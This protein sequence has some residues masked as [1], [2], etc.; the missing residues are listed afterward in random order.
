MPFPGQ[1][2][3]HAMLLGQGRFLCL[4]D[5]T[6]V[7]RAL[8]ASGFWKSWLSVQAEQTGFLLELLYLLVKLLLEESVML[9]PVKTPL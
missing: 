8:T 7:V 4:R 9:T 5:L 3:N 1:G 6:Q 2:S